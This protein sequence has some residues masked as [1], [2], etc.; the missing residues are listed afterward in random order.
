MVGITIHAQA[1]SF[2]AM[3]ADGYTSHLIAKLEALDEARFPYL[4]GRK[5]R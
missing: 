1:E 2:A 4:T 3:D 5:I